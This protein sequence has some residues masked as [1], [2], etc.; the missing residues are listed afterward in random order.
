MRGLVIVVGE[1]LC[2]VIR[3]RLMGL[4]MLRCDQ[5]FMKAE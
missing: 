4:M 5:T 1:L 3:H 2:R